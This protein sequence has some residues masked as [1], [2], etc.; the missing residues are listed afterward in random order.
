M[1]AMIPDTWLYA[2][3][4][5]FRDLTFSIILVQSKMN[6]IVLS[7]PLNFLCNV[8]FTPERSSFVYINDMFSSI[9][10]STETF[11]FNKKK[12]F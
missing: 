10:H 12:K 2:L 5:T 9:Q 1:K 4:L 6:F 8:P 7:L 11:F 3:W